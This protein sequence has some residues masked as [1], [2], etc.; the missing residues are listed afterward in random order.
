LEISSAGILLKQTSYPQKGSTRG[1][2]ENSTDN[3]MKMQHLAMGHQLSKIDSPPLLQYISLANMPPHCTD[4]PN[5]LGFDP[6]SV[7]ITLEGVVK[8]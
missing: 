3:N 5:K 6:S 2:K 4:R 8:K 1:R 7:H